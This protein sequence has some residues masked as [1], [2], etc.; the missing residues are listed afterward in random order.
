MIRYL[1]ATSVPGANPAPREPSVRRNVAGSCDARSASG[2]VKSSCL[3]IGIRHYAADWRLFRCSAGA[4]NSGAHARSV[5]SVTPMT[6]LPGSQLGRYEVRGPLGAGGMGEVYLGWD[7]T[8]E[9]E[10]AIKVLHRTARARR[11]TR[12]RLALGSLRR[13][14]RGSDHRVAARTRLS[15]NAT[16]HRRHAHRLSRPGAGP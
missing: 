11:R 15:R 2:V 8:L 6:L 4:E 7:P 12:S 13:L 9:R 3:S 1:A 10:V 14:R 16:G 5:Q